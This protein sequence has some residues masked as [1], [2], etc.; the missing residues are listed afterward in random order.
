MVGFVKHYIDYNE[1]VVDCGLICYYPVVI[2]NHEQKPMTK[3]KKNRRDVLEQRREDSRAA[4]RRVVEIAGSQQAVAHE[5]G[6]TQQAINKWLVRGYVPLRRAMELEMSFGV[7]R[8]SLADPR[9]VDLLTPAT[10]SE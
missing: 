5:L 9:V 1:T 4:L 3:I 6:V 7:S 2:H 8:A 10:M